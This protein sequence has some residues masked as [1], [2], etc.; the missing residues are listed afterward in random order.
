MSFLVR[1]EEAGDL[2]ACFL[3]AIQSVTCHGNTGR[4]KAASG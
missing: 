4:Q 1:K 3:S 2:P